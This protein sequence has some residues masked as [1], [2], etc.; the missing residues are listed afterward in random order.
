M[1]LKDGPSF[2]QFHAYWELLYRALFLKAPDY[3]FQ[4]KLSPPS[5]KSVEQLICQ[6]P[7]TTL[8]KI[9]VPV[10]Q[11]ING[12]QLG[13]IQDELDEQEENIMNEVKMD[14]ENE[15]ATASHTVRCS[16]VVTILS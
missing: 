5:T 1:D 13:E 15:L 8:P 3:G 9:S 6:F 4:L 14:T 7:E 11:S 16:F 2:E 12:P 10:S